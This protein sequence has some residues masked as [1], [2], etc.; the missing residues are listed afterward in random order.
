MMYHASPLA[1][2]RLSL[3]VQTHSWLRTD[4][5]LHKTSASIHNPFAVIK[6]HQGR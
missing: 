3:Y 5:K 6:E 1:T 2:L 4:D